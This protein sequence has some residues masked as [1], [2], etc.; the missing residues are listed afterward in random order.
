MRRVASTNGSSK[1]DSLIGSG[2]SRLEPSWE[3][4]MERAFYAH[5]AEGHLRVRYDLAEY[6]LPPHAA[7]D[8]PF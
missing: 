8:A 1:V 7:T 3:P 6:G 4:S 2:R 5:L